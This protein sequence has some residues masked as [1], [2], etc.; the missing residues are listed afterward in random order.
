VSAVNAVRALVWVQWRREQ[1]RHREFV[2]EVCVFKVSRGNWRARLTFQ[3]GTV[4]TSN[5]YAMSL[6]PY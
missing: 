3:H 2:E 4:I 6:P 5:Y 1:L